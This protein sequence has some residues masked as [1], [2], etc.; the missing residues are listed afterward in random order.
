VTRDNDFTI[1]DRIVRPQRFRI[2]GGDGPVRVKPKSMAVLEVLAGA[3]GRVVSR[4]ELFDAV[5][6]GSAVSDDTLTQCIVELRKAFGDTAKEARVIETIPRGGFRLVP[7]VTELPPADSPSDETARRRIRPLVLAGGILLAVLVPLTFY[8]SDNESEPPAVADTSA[9]TTLAVLPF[10]DVSPFGD[11][12]WI[13]DGLSDELINRLS[14]L[15]GLRVIG[16][17]SSFRFKD[18][19]EELHTIGETL[20]VEHILE[21]SVRHSGDELR[22]SAQLVNVNDGYQL[23]SDRYERP[24]ADVFDIQ[25]E[26]AESVA[27]ALSIRLSVGELGSMEGNTT[28]VAAY[29]EVMRGHVTANDLEAGGLLRAIRHY[30]RATQIDP[31]YAL[32]WAVLADAHRNVW[33]VLGRGERERHR[34]LS[35]AALEEAR[36]L[37]PSSPKV[38]AAEAFMHLD[39]QQWLEVERTL[40]RAGELDASMEGTDYRI[41]LLIKTGRTTQAVRSLEIARRQDPL[42][43]GT[44]VYLGHLYAMQGRLGEANDILEQGFAR[45]GREAAVAF[46]GVIN[47]LAIGDP[48]L[49]DRWL[50]R[51]AEHEQPGALDVHRTLSGLI[52]DRNAAVRWLRDTYDRTYELD[53]FIAIFAAYY[54]ETELAL[55][56]MQRTPDA[57]AFWLPVMAEVR[58][59][60][61]FK[62]LVRDVGLVEYWREYGWSDFCRPL[63]GE[64]FECS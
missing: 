20:G 4:N 52:H 37:A 64:D 25:Q 41:D 48:A 7:P 26:I 28:N 47:A 1:G 15:E 62:A 58:R 19:T 5:W 35:N 22:I 30:T 34:E 29:E 33:L 43:S 16:R 21:G 49:I 42:G 10:A 31:E 39:R 6:P 60:P 3:R 45:E 14:Q 13:A 32:A 18:S 36:R 9:V 8:F 40:A 2:E 46:E 38:I 23:W 57:W 17:T 51:A 53:F 27:T 56:A 61:G 44:A 55:S 24:M 59:E 63:A 54:D 50:A 12:D 11:R